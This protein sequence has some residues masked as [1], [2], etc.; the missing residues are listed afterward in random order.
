MKPFAPVDGFLVL[1]EV[2]NHYLM[3][4]HVVVLASE[5]RVISQ[6]NYQLEMIVTVQSGKFL[7]LQMWSMPCHY[8]DDRTEGKSRASTKEL[9]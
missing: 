6:S 4:G 8:W 1:V 9:V 7:R 2:E 5:I 3:K